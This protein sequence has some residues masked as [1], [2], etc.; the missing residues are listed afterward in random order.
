MDDILQQL[1][2]V[3]LELVLDAIGQHIDGGGGG[4]TDGHR[5]PAAAAAASAAGNATAAGSGASRDR[6]KRD[7]HCERARIHRE[8]LRSQRSHQHVPGASQHSLARALQ[9]SLNLTAQTDGHH[10]IHK[11]KRKKLFKYR[12]QIVCMSLCMSRMAT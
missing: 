3:V 8:S 11:K 7:G 5:V 9:Q 10:Q 12:Q 2:Q 4:G 6:G 1:G